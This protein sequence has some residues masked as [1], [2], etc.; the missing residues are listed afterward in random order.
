MGLGTG[1]QT[2]LTRHCFD[3]AR[4]HVRDESL[5]WPAHGR[6]RLKGNEDDPLELYEVGYVGR[7]P[8]TPPKDSDKAKR[9]VVDP[10]D[11]TG[12]WRPASG[13]AVP[14]RDGWIL[15]SKLGEGGFGEVWL[16][17]H[18][19]TKQTRVF[20]FC[21]DAERLR[22][23]KRELTF[24]KLIQRELGNRPDFVTLHEVQVEKPPY[25]L[26]SEFVEGGNLADWLEKR[27]G[28]AHWPLDA[29]LKFLAGVAKAVAAAH[30]LGII[31]KDLK[32][33]NIL[34]SESKT[35]EALP[36]LADF[37]IGVLA[38]RSKLVQGNVTETGFT[39][40]ILF[41]NESSR[42]GTRL[43]A[44]PESQLGKA[45]TT[46]TDVFALGV[47]LF[48]F[49]AGDLHKPLGTGW[50]DDLP[51][52]DPDRH[53]L[54]VDD[55]TQAT[56]SDPDK[57]TPSA[58]D[59]VERLNRLDARII[60]RKEQAER[61]ER[62]R[63]AEQQ[64]NR[65]RFARRVAAGAL[66]A[67]V[68]FSA[69]A[70]F[71]WM[72]RNAAIQAEAK[73]TQARIEAENATVAERSAREEE[74]LQRQKAEKAYAKT[75][76]VLDTMVSSITGDS[77][78]TQTT[79]TPEQKKFLSEVLSYY[80]EFADAKGVTETTRARAAKAAF[81]TGLIEFRLG[82]M[83]ESAKAFHQAS[84]D[85]MSLNRDFP[86]VLLYRQDSANS[87]ANLGIIYSRLG[88]PTEAEDHDLKALGIWEQLV[89]EYP[90]NPYHLNGL[91]NVRDHLGNLLSE[92]GKPAEAEVHYRKA[93]SIRESL[94]L[95]YPANLNYRDK[96]AI[97][98][99]NLAG[100]IDDLGK[101]TES[102][103][104]Y[105]KSF[106]IW[107]SLVRENPSVAEYRKSLSTFHYNAG[108]HFRNS[109]NLKRQE[110]EFRKALNLQEPLVREFPAVAEYRNSLAKTHS[111]LGAVYSDL[112]K[113][114]DSEEQ[115]RKELNIRKALVRDFPTIPEYRD[116][117]SRCHIF[118]GFL[119]RERNQVAMAIEEFRS[120]YTVMV[121]LSRDFPTKPKYQIDLAD[122][123]DILAGELVTAGKL[124]EAEELIRKSVS[125]REK[126]IR[127]N[128]NNK[129]YK[130]FLGMCYSQ[131]GNILQGRGKPIE[132]LHWFDRAITLMQDDYDQGDQ[133]P[134]TKNTLLLNYRLRAKLNDEL[135]N[136][137]KAV[138][139][140]DR[141]IEF[142][143][144]SEHRFYRANRAYSKVQ[145]GQYASA[146][147]DVVELRKIPNWTPDQIYNFACIYSIAS[148][149]MPDK[150]TEYIN[151][152][153][154]LIQLAV[155]A[156]FKDHVNIKAD[157]DLEPL[158]ERDD[159][160]KLIADLE[161]KYP[162]KK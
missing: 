120:G 70:M 25:F 14:R 78:A 43:Y 34:V 153:M 89:K 103:E 67:T 29:R 41:G 160:K 49:V 16:V 102:E 73:A 161:A 31:H 98:C 143:P 111:R 150:K 115:F 129:N 26:E 141:T 135:K 132:S 77:L 72:Q 83:A 152:A 139:D 8:L 80:R 50:Q 151:T 37:G 62:D 118:L 123:C 162:V 65:L 68:A 23:F 17:R 36:L 128:P 6:Y 58:A 21:F 18:K 145:A 138:S 63:R 137:N 10:D 42:T 20:K 56:R 55:I 147:A 88:K 40:S 142:S 96:L 69:I 57:R 105:R 84:D 159:F 121:S 124:A 158:R 149:N 27:G 28:L 90:D 140:W 108:L 154:E 61:A 75:V 116:L 117:L 127:D 48:Q 79:I 1:G 76:D 39:E 13:L 30:S 60:E 109:K 32:P 12:S 33:S 85:H 146:I 136:Y 35:G 91:G 93:L 9:V 113:Q 86:S 66:A 106:T 112:R 94:V 38:D 71:A 99:N 11:D 130:S 45:A 7:S 4:Q 126:L 92:M 156:G 59:F 157:G 144:P 100:T 44:P 24:F 22:S 155:K 97:I 51:A 3:S 95:K 15:D 131:L 134:S 148:R 87:L 81:G 125:I 54:L 110:E 5:S 107:D 74:R 133:S 114:D 64:A 119:L 122:N 101:Q 104:L 82:R 2:L 53:A 19:R 52:I 46:G 47:M